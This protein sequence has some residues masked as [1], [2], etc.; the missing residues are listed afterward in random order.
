[1]AEEGPAELPELEHEVVVLAGRPL[2]RSLERL[3]FLLLPLFL[4]LDR[5]RV[6]LDLGGGGGGGA[7]GEALACEK[8]HH[9]REAL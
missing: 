9:V 8:A 7:A 6:L 1:M 3:R 5:S 4:L 2:A